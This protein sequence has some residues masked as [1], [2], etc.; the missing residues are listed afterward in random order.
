MKQQHIFYTVYVNPQNYR[1]VISDRVQATDICNI[2]L[3]ACVLKPLILIEKIC[4]AITVVN[5]SLFGHTNWF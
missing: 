1:I 3:T 4:K 2:Q 5:A